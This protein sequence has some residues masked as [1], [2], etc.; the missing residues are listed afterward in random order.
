MCFGHLFSGIV[1]EPCPPEGG[2]QP[3]PAAP[4]N[5]AGVGGAGVAAIAQGPRQILPISGAHVSPGTCSVLSAMG[6]FVFLSSLPLDS[7]RSLFH[8][9]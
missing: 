2:T 4:V 5:P 6:R 1:E 9:F 7:F 3:P 8:L